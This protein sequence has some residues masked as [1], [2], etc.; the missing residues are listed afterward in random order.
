MLRNDARLAKISVEKFRK[1]AFLLSYILHY[2]SRMST[3]GWWACP[4]VTT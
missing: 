4:V 2:R 1:V 3:I